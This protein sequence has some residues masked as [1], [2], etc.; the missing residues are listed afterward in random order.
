[1][2]RQILITRAAQKPIKVTTIS[3]K[4]SVQVKNKLASRTKRNYFRT[5]IGHESM[6]AKH[7]KVLTVINRDQT[8]TTTTMYRHRTTS[9]PVAAVEGSTVATLTAT[10]RRSR[11]IHLFSTSPSRSPSTSSFS[12]EKS[13]AY[14]RTKFRDR[15][16]RTL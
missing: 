8:T 1:M 16:A 14:M 10:G 11:S 5:L 4:S 15:C 3:E 7:H 6:L 12:S 9:V 13:M 2:Q